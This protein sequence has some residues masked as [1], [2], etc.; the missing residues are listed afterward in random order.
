MTGFK[1][2]YFS[3]GKTVLDEHWGSK[4]MSVDEF[5]LCYVISGEI[6]IDFLGE[7]LTVKTGE[8]IFVPSKICHGFHLATK[9]KTEKYWMTFH[10]KDGGLNP[11]RSIKTP[12][13]TAVKDREF[14]SLCYDKILSLSNS[15]DSYNK[16]KL[17]RLCL[18]LIDDF[19]QSCNIHSTDSDSDKIAE[20]ISYMASSVKNDINLQDLSERAGYATNY[21]IRKFKNMTGYSPMQYLQKIRIERARNLLETTSMP[22]SSVMRE[23]GFSDASHFS[24]AFYS[25]VGYSP[26]VYRETFKKI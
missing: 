5:S 11:F 2:K 10:I 6:G 20:A 17:T 4:N 7:T 19:M 15:S 3:G 9:D 25:A 8:M 21:F 23:S 22:I 12:I 24:R 13:K 1:F 18:D 14:V 26:R 16:L